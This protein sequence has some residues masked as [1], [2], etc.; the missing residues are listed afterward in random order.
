MGTPGRG[1]ILSRPAGRKVA[2]SMPHSSRGLGHSPLKAEIIGSNPICG[3][4][5]LLSNAPGPRPG[6]VRHFGGVSR[7]AALFG[8]E[9]ASLGPL[10]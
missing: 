10:P 1:L 6:G 7:T 4:N 9:A 8:A 5:S 2:A 3:T